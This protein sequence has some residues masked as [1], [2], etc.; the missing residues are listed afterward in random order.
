MGMGMGMAEGFSVSWHGE[1]AWG[2]VYGRSERN[3]HD[4]LLVQRSAVEIV[5]G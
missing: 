3:G 2:F 5:K 4:I 1:G